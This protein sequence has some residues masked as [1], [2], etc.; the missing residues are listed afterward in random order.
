MVP[1]TA[2][3]KWPSPGPAPDWATP[4]LTPTPASGA[5]LGPEEVLSGAAE[6][7]ELFREGLSPHLGVVTAL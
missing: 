7:R 6:Q 5:G 3:A 2:L 4:S 1:G